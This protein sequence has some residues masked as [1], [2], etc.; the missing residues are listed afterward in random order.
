MGYTNEDYIEFNINGQKGKVNLE[1]Y[2][3]MMEWYKEL[4]KSRER[5][6]TIDLKGPGIENINPFWIEY[7]EK[8]GIK[9]INKP[10]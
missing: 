2:S 1:E 9:F 5:K 7:M 8:Q 10:E 6:F 3:K 4:E